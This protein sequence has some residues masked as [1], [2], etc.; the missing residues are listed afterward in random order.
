MEERLNSMKDGS[1]GLADSTNF[2]RLVGSLQYLTATRPDMMYGVGIVSRFIQTPHQ[3]HLKAAK[4]ILRYV[5]ASQATRALSRSRSPVQQAINYASPTPRKKVVLADFVTP[6]SGVKSPP[7]LPPSSK[8]C[9]SSQPPRSV[10]PTND[11][12]ILTSRAQATLL[13]RGYKSPTLDIPTGTSNPS[14]HPLIHFPN[15]ALSESC[16][17]KETGLGDATPLW[18]FCLIRYVAGKFPGYAS[19]LHFIGKHKAKFTIHDSGWLIF[20]FHSELEMVETMS[21][22]PYFMFGRPLI[23]KIMPEFF[24]FQAS[25]MTKLPTWVKLPNLH[26]RCWTPL[27]LSKL[28]SII[29]KP[30][31]CDIP[32][33]NMSRLFYARIMIEVDLLQELPNAIQVVLPNGRLSLNRSLMNPS[34]VAINF[35]TR[36]P[37]EDTT[38][39][40]KQHPY[41]VGPP[42]DPHVN[43]V[44]TKTSIVDNLKTQSLGCKRSK[45]TA[46][47]TKQSTTLNFVHISEEG[48]T[49][50][51]KALRRQYL[52]RSRAATTSDAILQEKQKLKGLVVVPMSMSSSDDIAPSSTF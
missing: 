49:P 6:S 5:K 39:V 19:L 7:S 44:C 27:C 3:S 52:M 35:V 16:Q 21:V 12:H 33:A 23:L 28:S 45:I 31:H 36:I 29:G 34:P 24:D 11:G 47:S 2:K 8:K 18:R 30:I 20:A 10:P 43:P 50:T 42:A 38:A 48:D 14:P 40:E 26:M 13:S 15:F 46:T 17:L 41:C 51:I 9:S 37:F 1:G 25:N 22:V 32:T 4:Y